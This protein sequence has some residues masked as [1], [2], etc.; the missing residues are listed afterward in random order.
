MDETKTTRREE[1][2]V[3]VG[4]CVRTTSS[5]TSVWPEKVAT[6]C[7]VESLE[8][9]ELMSHMQTSE[10]SEPLTNCQV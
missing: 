7:I 9:P 5:T 3:C 2:F 1:T 4:A 10:S 8:L 6:A